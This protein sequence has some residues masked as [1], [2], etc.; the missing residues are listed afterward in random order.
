M[1]ELIYWICC[2][3]LGPDMIPFLRLRS[4]GRSP[5][6]FLY[7][8]WIFL[9]GPRK[10]EKV[11]AQSYAFYV[12]TCIRSALT[13]TSSYFFLNRKRKRSLGRRSERVQPLHST[14]KFLD[15]EENFGSWSRPLCIGLKISKICTRM[16][17]GPPQL[18]NRNHVLTCK[19]TRVP[20]VWKLV[21]YL[22]LES[23]KCVFRVDFIEKSSKQKCQEK[24]KS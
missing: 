21:K 19:L 5:L 4:W 24:S 12:E 16:R 22:F 20:L 2:E 10:V 13:R 1:F 18:Q 17:V 15:H 9:I 11:F 3:S 7:I 23:S 6:S 14:G 8:F